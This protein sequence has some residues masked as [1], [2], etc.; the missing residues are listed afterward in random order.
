MESDWNIA[1]PG[2]FERMIISSSPVIRGFM[3]IVPASQAQKPFFP[4]GLLQTNIWV[5]GF[6]DGGGMESDQFARINFRRYDPESPNPE[7]DMGDEFSLVFPEGSS[8]YQEID[9]VGTAFGLAAGRFVQLKP[10]MLFWQDG[11]GRIRDL[12]DAAEPHFLQCLCRIESLIVEKYFK[13]KNR[14]FLASIR[15]QLR[16]Y[17][18]QKNRAAEK[19]LGLAVV[20]PRYSR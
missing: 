11:G 13:T 15:S 18:N 16:A 17:I 1:N 7:M 3:Q 5:F 14:T 9:L 20:T 12:S 10:V 19:S 8:L 6:Y 4:D 2:S